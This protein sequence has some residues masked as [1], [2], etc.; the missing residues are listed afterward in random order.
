MHGFSD[1]AG[2][3]MQLHFQLPN[4][5]S[6]VRMWRERQIQRDGA[7]VDISDD[8]SVF[9]PTVMEVNRSGRPVTG[10][11]VGRGGFVVRGV[12]PLRSP[13]GRFSGSRLP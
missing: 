9:R 3:P 2:A 11:E 8:I 4:G 10:I 13:D 12:T 7:W 5:R 6:L 1:A